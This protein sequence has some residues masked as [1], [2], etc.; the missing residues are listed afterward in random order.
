MAVLV[1]GNE[2]VLTGTVGDL[3]WD[4][5]FSS[6]DVIMA[7]AQVGRSQDV[8]V[9]INSGGGIATEGAAIHSALAA[10][11][12]TKTIIVEGIAASAAS[13]I[14][15]AG[16]E[17]VMAAGALM[18]VHDPSGFTF[19]TV[20]DHQLQIRAL[21]ALATAM[22]GI[23]ADKTGKTV[24]ETRMDMQAELW[25]TPEDAVTAG[26]ADRVQ[27]RASNDNTVAEPTAF[28]FRLYQHPPERLVALAD[29]HAWTKRTRHLAASP[30]NPPRQ[31]ENPMAND[32]AGQKPATKTDH[33]AALEA[34][35]N[36]AVAEA[37]ATTISRSD[38]SEIVK[39]CM[40]GGVPAMATSLLAEG[41]TLA[42]AKTRVGA[43]SQIKDLVALARRANPEI[44]ANTAD[45]FLAEGKTVEQAR[46]A[47]FD[48]MVAKQE[49]NEI[50][51]HIPASTAAAGR[52]ATAANMQRQL[53]R[54]GLVKKGA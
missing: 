53:E 48:K 39:A 37:R 25:M 11:K 44:P 42:E 8:V 9:R 50:R 21:T 54:S 47:L 35:V 17:V 16:D 18:M 2:I 5:S 38:A 41:V 33:Q 6:A 30:V 43:A 4:E 36:S 32:P 24:D 28:D 34:A 31:M 52:E 13:V 26:Y 3:F 1:D 23:Y 12:G 27:N 22:A 40:D 46:A 29:Q 14:A 45:T 20:A 49:A 19:G 7:L 10:H 15:M 51:S